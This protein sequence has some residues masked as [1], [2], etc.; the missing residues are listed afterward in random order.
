LKVATDTGSSGVFV[1]NRL[2]DAL[3]VARPQNLDTLLSSGSGD[4]GSEP[5][6]TTIAAPDMFSDF[7]WL[8][9]YPSP[10]DYP[11]F[12]AAGTSSAQATDPLPGHLMQ[13][14]QQVLSAPVSD[15]NLQ[16]GDKD[17]IDSAEYQSTREVPSARQVLK[18]KG[19]SKC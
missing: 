5:N 7:F 11:S 10:F 9:H 2:E 12:Y 19:K 17:S 8:E 6:S 4:P 1:H 13:P 16:E 18:F 14:Q 15:Q 3:P